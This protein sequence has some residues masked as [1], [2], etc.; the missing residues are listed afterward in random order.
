[1]VQDRSDGSRLSVF[2]RGTQICRD[3][4]PYPTVQLVSVPQPQDG[5]YREGFAHCAGGR[6]TDRRARTVA[7]TAAAPRGHGLLP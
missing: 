7:A 1:M 3:A 5:V 6:S 4:L 2:P